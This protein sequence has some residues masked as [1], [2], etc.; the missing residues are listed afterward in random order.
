MFI[1]QSDWGP[2]KVKAFM[3]LASISTIQTWDNLHR[4][5]WIGPRSV[6]YV[7]DRG[8]HQSSSTVLLVLDLLVGAC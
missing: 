1:R 8:R 6:R 7:V 4:R 5:G 2:L 3:W